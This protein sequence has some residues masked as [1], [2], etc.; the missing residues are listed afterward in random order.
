MELLSQTLGHDVQ[1]LAVV[2]T[3]NSVHNHAVERVELPMHVVNGQQQVVEEGSQW[4]VEPNGRDAYTES[5]AAR[6]SPQRRVPP[7][8]FNRTAYQPSRS[9]VLTKDLCDRA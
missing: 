4:C 9:G 3:R 2:G 8:R 7:P 6:P 1:A 5:V